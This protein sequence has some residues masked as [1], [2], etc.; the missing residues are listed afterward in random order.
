MAA[1]DQLA[2]R[3]RKIRRRPSASE[4]RPRYF[5]PPRKL[6]GLGEQSALDTDRN[7]PG[8]RLWTNHAA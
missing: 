3:R 6:I 7:L 1:S 2:V 8:G 5:V 4:L